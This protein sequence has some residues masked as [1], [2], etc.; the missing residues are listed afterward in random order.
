MDT[1][2]QLLETAPRLVQCAT[3]LYVC[4]IL[5]RLE[6]HLTRPGKVGLW[7]TLYIFMVLSGMKWNCA[8]LARA[9]AGEIHA[10]ILPSAVNFPSAVKMAIQIVGGSLGFLNVCDRMCGRGLR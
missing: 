6:R 9:R 7:R 2:P 3:E 8:P 5:T 4:A 1:V 10:G